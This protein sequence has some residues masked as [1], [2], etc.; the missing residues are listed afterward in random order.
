VR[1]R[2][3][4]PGDAAAWARMRCAL[5]PE[6]GDQAGEVAR[7]FAGGLVEPLAVLVAE[8]GGALVGFAEL[9]IRNIAESCVSGRVAYLEGWYVEPAHRRRGVGRALVLAA[10]EWGRAQGCPEFASDTQIDNEAS[11]AA[12]LAL[13]FAETDRIRCFR[14]E[15]AKNW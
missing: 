14:K 7:F 6:D 4:V 11:A 12:H 10:E 1:V 9:S 5:W 8:E 2:A 3:A 15:L 13:G